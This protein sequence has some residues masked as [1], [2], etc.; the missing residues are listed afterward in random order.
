MLLPLRLAP[1]MRQRI[2]LHALVQRHSSKVA[3]PKYDPTA[4]RPNQVCD[5]YG[6]GGQPMSVQQA[7]RY[8]GTIDNAWELERD[9]E[10]EPPVALKRIFLHADFLTGADFVRRLAAVAQVNNH[11]PSLMLERRIHKKN[12]QVVTEVKCSTVVLGGLS[13]SDFHLAMVSW[14]FLQRVVCRS[15]LLSSETQEFSSCAVLPD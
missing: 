5:P 1:L 2:S 15:R 14:L 4:R 7:M 3:R 13:A 6:Q 9:S 11:Y 12:W 8:K 10:E